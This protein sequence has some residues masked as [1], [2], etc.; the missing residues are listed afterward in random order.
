MASEL[1]ARTRGAGAEAAAAPSSSPPSSF[2]SHDALLESLGLHLRGDPAANVGAP[3]PQAKSSGHLGASDAPSLRLRWDLEGDAAS[4]LGGDGLR[5]R[6]RAPPPLRFGEDDAVADSDEG[7]SFELPHSNRA[8]KREERR[9]EWRQRRR[10][11]CPTPPPE[12]PDLRLEHLLHLIDGDDDLDALLDDQASVGVSPDD[13]RARLGESRAGLSKEDVCADGECIKSF[14][15]V[16]RLRTALEQIR[17]PRHEAGP[18]PARNPHRLEILTHGVKAG[19]ELTSCSR[20]PLF[21]R[22][23][24]LDQIF[25]L[26]GAVIHHLKAEFTEE[27]S[28]VQMPERLLEG[29]SKAQD[30]PTVSL[31]EEL[32]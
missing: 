24:F 18:D 17:V 19:A 14:E 6:C 32:R 23:K 3:P 4:S 9:G 10:K 12:P 11:R 29:L 13:A 8:A 20:L 30:P 16:K 21:A 15:K 7:T 1:E 28:V 25:D 27:H 31:A 2:D 22:E 5:W 26:L